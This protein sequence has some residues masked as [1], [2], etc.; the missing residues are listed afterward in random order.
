MKKPLVLLCIVAFAVNAC[1]SDCSCV[2]PPEGSQIHGEWEFV[3]VN[4]PMT[5]STA[6][7]LELGYTERLTIAADRKIFV[8]YRDE[9]V[10]ESTDF[11][12][13]TQE[14]STTII[15]KKESTY[16]YYKVFLEGERTMLSLYERSPV[17]SILFDG[18]TYYYQKK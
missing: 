3:R 18:G 11:E 10:V 17:G 12:L 9:K 6:T 1:N 14:N 2:P 7:A 4:Y 13:S 8:R 15:F 5:N 16:T